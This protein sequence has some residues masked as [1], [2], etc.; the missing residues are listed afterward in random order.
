MGHP[1]NREFVDKEYGQFL[2]PV[3]ETN[4]KI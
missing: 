1:S 2:A 4:K 3:S